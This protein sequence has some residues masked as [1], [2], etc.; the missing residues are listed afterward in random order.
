MK[1]KSDIKTVEIE[2]LFK[3]NYDL[4]CLAAFGILKDRD[5][6]RDIV[7]DFFVFYWQKRDTVSINI[8][9]RAYA[10]RAVKNLSLL[11]LKNVKKEQ[12]LLRDLIAEENEVKAP[13]DPQCPYNKVFELINQL[14]RSRREIFI[15]SVMHG[16]SYSEIAE[17]YNISVNTVKTQIKRA[18][19]FLRA[20]VS[21]E[22]L[23]YQFVLA[24]SAAWEIL[25]DTAF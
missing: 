10:V 8:S 5:A 1:A 21:K 24:S 7:Q 15:S 18:Y 16:Q 22:D 19:V 4:L 17:S 2:Q 6:A 25:L 14:P 9:F 12:S 11:S 20:R 13:Y 23:L 3:E